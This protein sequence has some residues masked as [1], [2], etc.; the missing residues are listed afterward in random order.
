M[1]EGAQEG[2]SLLKGE[3]EGFSHYHHSTPKRAQ[4]SAKSE[5]SKSARKILRES[6]DGEERR[7]RRVE[8]TEEISIREDILEN[9]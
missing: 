2:F 8:V 4:Y 9:Y 5:F 3:A 6:G 7:S 1:M